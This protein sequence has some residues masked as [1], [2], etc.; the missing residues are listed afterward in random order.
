MLGR[1]W[2]SSARQ[3]ASGPGSAGLAMDGLAGMT[4][5]GQAGDPGRASSQIVGL[6]IVVQPL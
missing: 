2:G 4:L 1:R 5:D 6:P 3:A